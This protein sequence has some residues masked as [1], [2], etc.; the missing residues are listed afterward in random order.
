MLATILT[1][2][3]RN[4]SYPGSR[5][6]G[7]EEEEAWDGEGERP[8]PSMQVSAGVK[9]SERKYLYKFCRKIH[10]R[11]IIFR[12]Y[13]TSTARSNYLNGM[14]YRVFSEEG[15]LVVEYDRAHLWINLENIGTDFMNLA[16]HG[17][18][19]PAGEDKVEDELESEEEVSDDEE[20][21]EDD[22]EEVEEEGVGEEKVG[23][24]QSGSNK[25]VHSSSKSKESDEDG[26]EDENDI[27]SDTHSSSHRGSRSGSEH[28]MVSEAEADSPFRTA[29]PS[30]TD[31]KTTSTGSTITGTNGVGLGLDDVKMTLEG[32]EEGEGKKEGVSPIKPPK[33]ESQPQ[34]Q[35][36]S[37]PSKPPKPT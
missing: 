15:S 19:V 25:S 7:V 24:T 9:K 17:D 21:E 4:L 5:G 31:S 20:E 28:T 34:P 26:D 1:N 23:N 13:S 29:E 11:E 16:S 14:F 36:V 12:P 27:F 22:E 10:K 32:S 6:G 8:P 2:L 18:W 3:M 35:P 30:K 37:S 33:P